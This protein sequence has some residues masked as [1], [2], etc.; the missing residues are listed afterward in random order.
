MNGLYSFLSL[1]GWY[2]TSSNPAVFVPNEKCATLVHQY[3]DTF[4]SRL[5]PEQKLAIVGEGVIF[6]DGKVKV[7]S[8]ATKHCP[9]S[10]AYLIEAESKRVLCSGDL[11]APDVDLPNV[12][13]L[14]AAIL[15]AAH[16]N[17]T[18]YAPVL[19]GRGIKAVYI[20][21]YGNYIGFINGANVCALQNELHPLPVVLTTDGMEIT[22]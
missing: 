17:A 20:N 15:E 10:H 19:K 18:A 8:F 4:G 3:L 9:N 22:L 16:F 11:F 12:D 6:D 13:D 14:D 1:I 5:R 21:H 7:T 2:Y